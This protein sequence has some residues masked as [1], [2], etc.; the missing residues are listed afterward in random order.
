MRVF[1]PRELARDPRGLAFGHL[2]YE[3]TMAFTGDMMMP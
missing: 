1:H 3:L 2:N